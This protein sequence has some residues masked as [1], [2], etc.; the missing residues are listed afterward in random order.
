MFR[1]I[2]QWFKARRSRKLFLRDYRMLCLT[3]RM[4][5]EIKRTD[6]RQRK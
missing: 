3:Q 2:I 5:E 1:K 6:D 4:L